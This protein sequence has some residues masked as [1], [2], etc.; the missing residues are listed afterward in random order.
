MY[1]SEREH[2]LRSALSTLQSIALLQRPF[3]FFLVSSHAHYWSDKMKNRPS[4]QGHAFTI[5][6]SHSR[7]TCSGLG[8]PLSCLMMMTVLDKKRIHRS[9]SFSTTTTMT[10]SSLACSYRPSQSRYPLSCLGRSSPRKLI[11]A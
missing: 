11:T 1:N 3:E 5:P 2:T 7:P 4:T 8:G 10:A 9:K 6:A